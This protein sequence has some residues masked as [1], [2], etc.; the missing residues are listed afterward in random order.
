MARKASGVNKNNHPRRTTHRRKTIKPAGRYQHQARSDQC[1]SSI[2]TALITAAAK[3][4][5]AW[6]A[7]GK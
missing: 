2:I 4:L 5:A 7:L 6:I 1:R 3:L